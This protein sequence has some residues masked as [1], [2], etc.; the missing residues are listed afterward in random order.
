[1]KNNVPY[2]MGKSYRK[3]GEILPSG[4]GG[5]GMIDRDRQMFGQR[6]LQNPH[7]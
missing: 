6:H 2:H 5:D 1:M 3:F 4:L 7:F